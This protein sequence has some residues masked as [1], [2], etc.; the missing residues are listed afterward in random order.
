MLCSIVYWYRNHSEVFTKHDHYN[1]TVRTRIS[2]VSSKNQNVLS[3]C[4]CTLVFVFVLYILSH[5]CG[6][7]IS[8]QVQTAV[9]QALDVVSD[10]VTN[11][12]SSVDVDFQL[13]FLDECL[14]DVELIDMLKDPAATG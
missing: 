10:T 6:I 5:F 2:C 13:K 4:A 3:F 12:L 7:D 1:V 8:G 14:A 11:W 9:E